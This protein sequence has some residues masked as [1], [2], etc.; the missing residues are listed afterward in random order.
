M[1]ATDTIALDGV[2]TR[3]ELENGA[4]SNGSGHWGFLADSHAWR[5]WA[6]RAGCWVSKKTGATYWFDDDG[7]QV[8]IDADGAVHV[9]P[10]H[11][12]TAWFVEL[13]PRGEA[14]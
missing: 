9:F 6:G 1:T 5:V 10:E 8:V 2:P 13:L 11:G 3:A 4:R 7:R 14:A 12:S